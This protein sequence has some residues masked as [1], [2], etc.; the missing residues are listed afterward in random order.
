MRK[1]VIYPLLILSVGLNVF[2]LVSRMNLNSSSKPVIYNSLLIEKY[3]EGQRFVLLN[4]GDYV[5]KES[6]SYLGIVDFYGNIEVI[7]KLDGHYEYLAYDR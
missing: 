1:K 6:D 7:M 5:S 2:L 4:E 3:Q